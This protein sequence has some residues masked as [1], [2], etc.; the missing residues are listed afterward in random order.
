MLAAFPDAGGDARA[1]A[2]HETRVDKV[3]AWVQ[4]PMP[5]LRPCTSRSRV[6][7]DYA[8]MVRNRANVAGGG[9][10]ALGRLMGDA[11]VVELQYFSWREAVDVL[12]ALGEGG[13]YV[14][15]RSE[16]TPT[17]TSAAQGPTLES[18]VD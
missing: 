5:T 6:L 17:G 7:L 4:E 8:G 10:T 9:L 2:T 3:V 12:R 15:D 18:A 11:E 13:E 14:F 1:I 16:A